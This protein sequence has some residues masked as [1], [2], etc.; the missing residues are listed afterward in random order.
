MRIRIAITA[1][2]LALACLPAAAG[3]VA[4]SQAS[5]APA[6]SKEA[7][8]AYDLDFVLP[9]AGKSG[10]LVCHGDPNLIRPSGD[11]T[12]SLFVSAQILQ[13]S[14][15]KDVL[16]TGCHLDF[17]YKV[18]HQNVKN[19]ADWRAVAKQSCNTAGCHEKEFAQ[20]I[21]GS[22]SPV[23]Q[24]GDDP[25]VVAAA[26]KAEGKPA[27]VPLC[28]DC[29]GS[30]AIGPL[31]DPS[32]RAAVHRSGLEMCGRCHEKASDSYVDYYHGAAYRRGALDAPACW[33]CH[34]AH[35]MRPTKDKLSLVNEQKLVATC[36]KCH[37]KVTDDYVNYAAMIHRSADVESEVPVNVWIGTAQDA[38]RQA[39]RK[40]RSWF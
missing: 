34:S 29:H 37:A 12:V 21:V 36:G 20:I 35:E 18:P 9:T 7:T 13:T 27:E 40:V 10:C 6:K 32:V 31:K 19:G 5:T 4:P 22:H 17:A 25:K 3:A 30:H 15:H 26:R 8:R 11:A 38:L 33:D 16:C 39:I 28:G 14:V 2:V 24:P 23:G 1:G